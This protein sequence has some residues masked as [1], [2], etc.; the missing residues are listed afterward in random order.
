M[1]GR[2]PRRRR[3]RRTRLRRAAS[4]Q[5]H[6]AASVASIEFPYRAR[7]RLLSKG[8]SA[9]F[10]ALHRAAEGRCL[11]FVKVR[12]ADVLRLPPHVPHVIR[13]PLNQRH[14]DFVL[15]T[16]DGITPFRVIEFDEQSR[17]DRAPTGR[18]LKTT[19]L[20]TAGIPLSHVRAAAAYPI[21]ELQLL[22]TPPQV[23]ETR[24]RAEGGAGIA[25]VER[26]L[27]DS[28]NVAMK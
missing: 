20:T 2:D 22:A 10:H 6:A 1:S 15:C 23:P 8:E 13:G 26:S 11:V 4:A 7:H 27:F 16:L 28:A 25:R 18:D 14:L 21:D 3:R 17:D 24:D 12:L 5:A 19:A 9:F